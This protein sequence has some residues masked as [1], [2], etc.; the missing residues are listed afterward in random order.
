MSIGV[1][2]L[3]KHFQLA[4]IET[5]FCSYFDIILPPLKGQSADSLKGH[6]C[7]LDTRYIK[8]T[9]YYIANSLENNDYN[10][11]L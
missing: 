9:L 4:F 11:L 2:S 6:G 10:K 5:I 8:N 3:S 1:S 7:L